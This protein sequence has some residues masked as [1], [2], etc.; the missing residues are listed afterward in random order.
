MVFALFRV[1]L[2]EFFMMLTRFEP[3]I[4]DLRHRYLLTRSRVKYLTQQQSY[5]LN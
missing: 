2:H 3:Q 4:T 1:V 5:Y